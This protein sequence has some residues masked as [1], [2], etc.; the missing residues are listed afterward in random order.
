MSL[1]FLD[2]G[3]ELARLRALLGRRAGSLAVVYGRRRLGK[4]RLLRAALP[5]GRAVYFAADL[6]ESALQRGALAAEIARLLPGFGDVTYPDWSS[7]LDRF[8]ASAPPGAV[9]AL[10]EF[11]ALVGAAPELPSI[12]QRRI[13]AARAAA[14]HLVLAGSSQRLMH[15]LVLDRTAPLFGRAREILK[16]EPLGAGWIGRALGLADEI[17]A[18]EAFAIW[19]GVPRYWELAAEYPA[20]LPAFETLVL[21]PLGVLHDE[22]RSLLLDDLR[23]TAQASSLLALVGAGA[24]RPSEIAARLG[25]PA[26]ALGRP[27]ARLLD[28]GLLR[29]DQPFGS[30]P[31]SAKRSLYRIADPFLAFW[32]A[33]VEPNRSRLA[34]RREGAVAQEV[35][36]ALPRHVAGVWEELVRASVPRANYCGSEWGAAARW[37]GPGADQAP[38]EVDVVAESTGGELLVGEA[39]W[40]ER[41]DAVRAAAALRAKA[42]RLPFAAGRK[43]RLALW[44]K[45][46]PRRA[47]PGVACFGPRAVLRALR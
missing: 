24:H 16:I 27:L 7:L 39:S 9:L 19:G 12:L 23:E 35:A 25:R 36:A 11:P 21:S 22:P 2:R 18:V 6:R 42:S 37:W 13:D 28:L 43:L 47:P 41:F 30:D 32:F 46:P 15:G 17:T 40:Q 26:T 45:R 10:D 8:W 14:P 1:P 3:P 38:L 44:S 33:F 29:R 31:R 5:R 20:L 4:S 34:A